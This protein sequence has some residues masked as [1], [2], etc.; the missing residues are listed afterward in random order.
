MK[1]ITKKV[2]LKRV[3]KIRSSWRWLKMAVE[4]KYRL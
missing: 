1:K 3:R 4:A 2:R